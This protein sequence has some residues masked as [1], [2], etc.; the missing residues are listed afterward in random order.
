MS[1]PS[2][3][4]FAEQMDRVAETGAGARR[5][6][7]VLPRGADGEANTQ[8]SVRAQ[9][10][11][12]DH[13]RLDSPPP[14]AEGTVRP[15]YAEGYTGEMSYAAG[16]TLEFHVS[17]SAA[18][19]HLEVARV[20][21]AVTSVLSVAGIAGAAHDVPENASSHGCGWPVA[22]AAAVR[23]IHAA[24]CMRGF[25][26]PSGGRCLSR[27][28]VIRGRTDPSWEK[29]VLSARGFRRVGRRSEYAI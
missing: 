14:R 10:F 8:Q 9:P 24:S 16:D 4:K 7:V 28:T 26:L 25:L 6:D 18:V 3:H 5:F 20:G 11:A 1:E 22:F 13:A 12:G 19:F 23:L 29:Q 27:P 15:L 2:K 21:G 17:T